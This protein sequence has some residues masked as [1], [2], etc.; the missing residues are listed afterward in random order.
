VVHEKFAA[1]Q[2][3]KV[4]KQMY[5]PHSDNGFVQ[6]WMVFFTLNDITTKR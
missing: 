1:T 5:D 3:G 6:G 2:K 4:K